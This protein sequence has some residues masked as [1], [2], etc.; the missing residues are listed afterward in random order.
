MQSAEATASSE[1]AGRCSRLNVQRR[2]LNGCE[3]LD[4]EGPKLWREE[5]VDRPEHR[6]RSIGK[7]TLHPEFK[8]RHRK[9]CGRPSRT[10]GFVE[11]VRQN[12]SEWIFT[13]Q[14]SARNSWIKPK[15]EESL[16]DPVLDAA[17]R[18]MEQ[19]ENLARYLRMKPNDGRP[20]H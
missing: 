2:C 14:K 3:L 17:H 12:A 13:V 4:V 18:H 11:L 20:G 9:R 10:V 15:D 7:S 1:T 16:W 19:G 5:D 6:G 8:I